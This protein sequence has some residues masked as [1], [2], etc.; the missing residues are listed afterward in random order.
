MYNVGQSVG[1]LV[2]VGEDGHRK[3]MS[4]VESRLGY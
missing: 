1:P 2:S 4:R 3:G